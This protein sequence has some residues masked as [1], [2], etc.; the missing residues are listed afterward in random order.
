MPNDKY[1]PTYLEWALGVISLLA[2]IVFNSL[3]GRISR[4]EDQ[5][6]PKSECLLIRQIDE[7]AIEQLA[8]D[9]SGMKKD[10]KEIYEVCNEIKISQ[11]SKK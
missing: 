1:T 2:T 3:R 6:M 10:I 11:A 4:L 7:R 5:Y 9:V 8:K